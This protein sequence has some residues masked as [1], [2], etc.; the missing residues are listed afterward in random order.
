MKLLIITTI[1]YPL[2]EGGKISQFAVIDELR[3]FID[4]TLIVQINSDVDMLNIEYLNKIWDNVS[5]EKIDFRVSK[6]KNYFINRIVNKVVK[7]SDRFN[8]SNDI[9]EISDFDLP[10]IIEITGMKSRIFIEKLVDIIYKIHP[11]IVQ[12][13]LLSLIDLVNVLPSNIKKVFVHHEIRFGRLESSI[14]MIKNS[15]IYEK[16][17]IENIKLIESAYLNL[18]DS[19]IVFSE[20]DKKKLEEVTHGVKIFDSPFPVLRNHFLFPVNTEMKF[21][22]LIFIGGEGHLPNKLAIE[23][24][25]KELSQLLAINL[26]LKL[27]VIGAWSNETIALYKN[28]PNLIFEGIVEDLISYCKDSIMLVP[29][30][31]GSGIR[32]KILYAMAQGIPV[33]SSLK[34]C[35]GINVKDKFNILIAETPRDYILSINYLINDKDFASNIVKNAYQYVHDFHTQ[36]YVALRRME[37]YERIIKSNE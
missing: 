27:F 23:W 36:E 33:I 7:L 8:I 19:I 37:C 31:V 35:E 4:I 18:Y 10:Y 32:T 13:E 16:Y 25:V 20:V 14:N 30:N 28:I 5:I 29:V 12:I 11:D 17:V 34:G 15:L 6:R 1:P 22:K 9:K 26:D 24:Y 21:R 3:K 2:L